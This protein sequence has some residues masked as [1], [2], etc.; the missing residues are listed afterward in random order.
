MKFKR[1]TKVRFM[2][3]FLAMSLLCTVFLFCSTITY[4]DSRLYFDE[5]G[6]LLFVSVSGKDYT[7]IKYRTIGWILKRYD[8][9]L[10]APGQQYAIIPKR[11]GG[12]TE[13]D[14]LNPDILI[15]YFKS[16][17]N[18]I[19][20]AIG[21]VS[22]EW[23]NQ[24]LSYGGDVY[25]DS[26]M[27]VVMYG[28]E[29]GSVSDSGELSGEVYCTFEGI[30]G[31]RPWGDPQSLGQF[32]NL[33][34]EYPAQTEVLKQQLKYNKTYSGYKSSVIN[35]L[36]LG[37]NEKDNEIYD[38]VRAV[39]SGEHLYVH[40][41]ISNYYYETKV[42]LV[43]GTLSVPVRVN[44]TYI[45]KWRGYDGSTKQETREVVR[46]YLVD[47]EFQY[48]EADSVDVYGINEL[49]VTNNCF[50]SVNFSKN[51]SGDITKSTNIYNDI[52]SHIIVN[53][54]GLTVHSGTK[55][56]TSDSYLK[57]AIPNEDYSSLAKKQVTGLSV[58]SDKIVI[59]NN[60]L[61]SD[62]LSENKGKSPVYF[63]PPL[64]N[65]YVKNIAIRNTARNGVY[66]SLCTLKYK[67]ISNGVK[68]NFNKS[69]ENVKVHTPIVCY[70]RLIEDRSNNQETAPIENT[71]VLGC[72]FN[73]NMGCDGFHSSNKG[74]GDR[75]YGKYIEKSQIKFP[76]KVEKNGVIYEKETW[77]DIN[78]EDSFVLPYEVLLG[79]YEVEI[80]N[81]A[82]NYIGGDS[83]GG[84]SA[85]TNSNEYFAYSRFN[86][87]VSGRLFDFTLQ[88]ENKVADLVVDTNNPESEIEFSM[89][90]AGNYE[91][92]DY[93]RINYI[94]SYYKEGER[95]PVNVYVINGRDGISGGALEDTKE[96]EDIYFRDSVEISENL[97]KLGGKL[98][99]GEEVYIFPKEIEINSIKDI[100][101]NYNKRLVGGY[102]VVGFDSY[103]YKDKKPYISYI[104]E[105]NSKNGYC[106][107]WKMEDFKYIQD[108]N[109]R[110]VELMSGDSICYFGKVKEYY[111]FKVVGTH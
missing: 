98:K 20:N 47:R 101:K 81:Y 26:V 84:E 52:M 28:M 15:C 17:R 91:G 74:Y 23:K 49:L 93:V 29:M 78:T 76:F 5:D 7:G 69:L 71:I 77:L 8:L 19:L 75:N 13:S 31:A 36:K 40:G 96:F 30:A 25:I 105:E 104:N 68:K 103:I 45:L 90:A 97:V 56:I 3:L 54:K 16:D 24:L 43:K 63:N 6:N 72:T 42:A 44:T 51:Y 35:N 37:S 57:P 64:S 41:T 59:G 107:M 79:D 80:R 50:D 87:H 110:R 82:T 111:D 108:I 22:T 62:E 109:G 10:D 70:G 67:N 92:E 83:A 39:P 21:R 66:Q 94:Y 1:I 48:Y 100:V 38:I 12:N 53:T 11:T 4:A 102:L 55:T 58:K 61:L 89:V 14:P 85:N 65:I 33:V 9:P 86:V 95:I 2:Q 99:L 106:N 18:E 60:V 46:Y 32:Y 27:T 34:I 88:E 73:I